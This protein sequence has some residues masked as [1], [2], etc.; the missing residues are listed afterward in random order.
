VA[1]VPRR[2]EGAAAA[3][4][5]VEGEF[6]FNV[7]GP[8]IVTHK[9]PVFRACCIVAVMVEADVA[10]GLGRLEVNGSRGIAVLSLDIVFLV[11]SIVFLV[12][13]FFRSI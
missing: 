13:G 6:V 4:V 1:A 8:A 7:C 10:I 3:M 9:S 12:L 5:W 11:Q 2:P